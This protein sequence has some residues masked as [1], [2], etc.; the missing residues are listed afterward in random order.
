MTPRPACRRGLTLVELMMSLAIV[1]L[2][3]VTIGGMLTAVAHGTDDEQSARALVARQ[4]T[5]TSRLN[6]AIRGS[7]QVLDAG[8]GWLVLW[9]RD[10]DGNDAPSLLEIRLIELDTANATLGSYAAPGGAAD[11][12]YTLSDNFD[13]ITQTLRGTADFPE[14]RCVGGV[15]AFA[16]SYDTADATAARLVSYR[17]R[18]TSGVNAYEAVGTALLRNHG[19]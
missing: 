11:V 3:G 8:D 7:R 2:I 15:Q 12:A 19:G 1:G 5:V 17:L 18:L 13:A 14:T 10:L 6:A 4:L 16:L 9:T